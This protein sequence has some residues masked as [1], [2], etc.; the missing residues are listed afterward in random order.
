MNRTIKDATVKHYFYETND[1][2]RKQFEIRGIPHQAQHISTSWRARK[3]PK[4]AGLSCFKVGLMYDTETI[5]RHLKAGVASIW[6]KLTSSE[7]ANAS[8]AHY[9]ATSA[10]IEADQMDRA[11]RT[12]REGVDTTLPAPP[13]QRDAE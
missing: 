13:P 12:W 9:R 3:A 2:L 11:Q 10:K 8:D 6:A 7:A 1:Q 4:G 5:A